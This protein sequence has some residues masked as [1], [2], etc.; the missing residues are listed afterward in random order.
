MCRLTNAACF[1]M[2]GEEF[3][4]TSP[5]L[6]VKSFH[7]GFWAIDVADEVMGNIERHMYRRPVFMQGRSAHLVLSIIF[8][9]TS[10]ADPSTHQVIV[11]LPGDHLFKDLLWGTSPH[12]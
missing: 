1:S 5:D 8:T 6:Y 2:H 4:G 11:Q 12:P 7:D 3:G 10:L 9:G